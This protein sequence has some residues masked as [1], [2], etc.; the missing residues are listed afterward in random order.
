MSRHQHIAVIGAGIVGL[1]T[2]KALTEA[3]ER[4]RI[5]ESGLP[6]YGQSAGD[7]RIFRHAHDD[8]RLVELARA[9]RGVWA[10]WEEKLAVQLVSADGVVALGKPAVERLE[11]LEEVGGVPARGIEEGEAR[12]RLPLLSEFSGPAV[13]D[14]GG[15]AIRARAAI[16]ALAGEL[17]D[18]LFPEEVISLRSTGGGVEVRTGR[19]CSE[20]SSVIVCAGRATARLARTAGLV[21]PIA[22]SA[23][24]RATFEVRGEAP[25]HLACLQDGSGDFGETGVYASPLPGN[26]RYAVGL[27]ET[28]E[29]LEDGSIL[30]PGAFSSLV[31]RVREYVTRALPG[32]DP[33]PVELLHCWVTEVPWSAD[34]LAVWERDGLLFVAGHNLF[35]MAPALGRSVAR[36]ALGEQ[37]ASQLRP[38]ARLG[39]APAPKFS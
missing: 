24:V 34:G 26:S 39:E 16:E 21:L 20:Y 18:S 9:S 17:G 11:V 25:A 6:G 4:V 28:I 13:F 8:P 22:L 3:G 1:A 27:S 35:K 19:D 37:L 29:V 10:E 30:D 14:A 15:G 36:A 38:E 2:A 23:H 33:Q 31:E 12:A 32:L 5:Y 7:S